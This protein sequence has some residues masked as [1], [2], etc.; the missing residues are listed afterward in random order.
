MKKI[1]FLLLIIYF[2]GIPLTGFSIVFVKIDEKGNHYYAC[3]GSSGHTFSIKRIEKKVYKVLG[4]YI[5]KT[6]NA[7][8]ESEV[9]LIVCDESSKPPQP[10]SSP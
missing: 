2:L 7:G 9:A 6:V 3:E 5:G 10:S 1:A 4:T 8:S